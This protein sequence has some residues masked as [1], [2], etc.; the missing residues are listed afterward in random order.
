MA[1]PIAHGLIG[2]S[3]AGLLAP[4]QTTAQN[5]K[6]ILICAVLAVLPDF[7]YLFYQFLDW[8]ESW[9]RS[10]SHSIVFSIIVGGLC[11]AAFGPF[12]TRLFLIY[13]LATLSHA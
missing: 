8:G 7:D 3:V 6:M 11:A 13:T 12:T 9:H 4:Q 1:L 2:A 10:F 5:V